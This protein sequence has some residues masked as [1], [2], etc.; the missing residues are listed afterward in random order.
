MLQTHVK[1]MCTDA[2]D[3]EFDAALFEPA[4][5]DS[6]DEGWFY[7]SDYQNCYNITER[8]QNYLKANMVK[9]NSAIY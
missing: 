7:N 2:N 9:F 4:G 8:V 1:P 3:V 5:I 6:V